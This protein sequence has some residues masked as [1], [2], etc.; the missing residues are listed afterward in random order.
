MSIYEMNFYDIRS[1]K[2]KFNFIFFSFSFMLM[3]DQVHAIQIAKSV[4]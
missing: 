3:P 2:E 1:L 4:L